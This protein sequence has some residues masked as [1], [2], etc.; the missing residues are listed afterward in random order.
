PELVGKCKAGAARNITAV[1]CDDDFDCN[2]NNECTG[3]AC[4]SGYCNY[5][6]VSDGASCSS[7]LCCGGTCNT[8]VCSDD[9]GCNDGN[10]CTVDS[11]L[12]A[13]TCSAECSHVAITSCVSGDSC[14]PRG[15][16][17]ESS[18]DTDCPPKKCEQGTCGFAVGEKS[19]IL[20]T[21]DAGAHWTQI[22]S[23]VVA[24]FYDVVFVN[25][26]HGYIV[27]LKS[28]PSEGVVLKTTDGGLTWT[29]QSTSFDGVFAYFYSVDFVNETAGFVTDMNGHVIY[30]SDG[31]TWVNKT[32]IPLMYTY[33]SDF[34]NA[35]HGWVA[36]GYKTVCRT[37]DGG[38]SWS[39]AS[40]S[41]SGLTYT[42]QNV[43]FINATHGWATEYGKDVMATTDGGVT[44]STQNHV[45]VGVN[46]NADFE[47]LDMINASHGWAGGNY[48]WDGYASYRTIDGQNWNGYIV[49]PVNV[50]VRSM[51][52]INASHGWATGNYQ[53]RIWST[54]DG[55]IT[56]NVQFSTT[57]I[58]RAVT[59]LL[60]PDEMLENT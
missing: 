25:S 13:N 44:W 33:G 35:T 2:D 52:F 16:T 53:G 48:Y 57:K 22:P 39:L 58:L 55:G 21:V 60:E 51:S 9:A 17:L 46:Y 49:Q 56:W 50:F 47:A 54:T 19:V 59:F 15:C 7:G 18:G 34:I 40:G 42:V 5:T 1:E 3:D 26:S 24:D 45:V 30:T 43:D 4:V 37:T 8:T 27:G 10:A 29:K 38:N 31:V 28:S 12:N 20:R 11:C 36:C 41:S 14:C 23:P 32:K 6:S